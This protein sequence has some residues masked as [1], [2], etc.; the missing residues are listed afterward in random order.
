MQFKIP[1]I[2]KKSAFGISDK[3]YTE[4]KSRT[5]KE[6]KSKSIGKIYE[7]SP[8]MIIMNMLNQPNDADNGIFRWKTKSICSLHRII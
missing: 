5:I 1:S 2:S 4:K 6:I 3:S 8:L 7:E